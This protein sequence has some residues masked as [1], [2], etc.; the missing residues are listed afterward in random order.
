MTRLCE[1]ASFQHLDTVGNFYQ[2]RHDGEDGWP[3]PLRREYTLSRAFK[4]SVV[5]FVVLAGTII[6]PV[7]EVH[8]VEILGEYGLEVGV[9]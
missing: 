5:S 3:T 4:E 2:I 1:K 9:L 8:I 7:C 6:G